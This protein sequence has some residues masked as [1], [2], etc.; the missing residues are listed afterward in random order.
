MDDKTNQEKGRSTK[1]ISLQPIFL[2]ESDAAMCLG[3]SPSFFRKNLLN[4]VIFPINPMH[5]SGIG[6]VRKIA[7]YDWMDVMRIAES[8]K[9]ANLKERAAARDPAA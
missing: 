8:W 7:L 9:Q 1:L 2:R 6:F 3:V 4:K 5:S